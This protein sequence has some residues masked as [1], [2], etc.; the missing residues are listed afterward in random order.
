MSGHPTAASNCDNTSC[1]D[2]REVTVTRSRL[3]RR[4]EISVSFIIQPLSREGARLSLSSHVELSMNTKDSDEEFIVT[5][6]LIV[7]DFDRSVSF[8]RDIL[9]ATVLRKGE[10]TLVRL[11]NIGSPSTSA[12]DQLMISR[13]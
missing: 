2:L 1:K 13:R 4:V 6:I 12:A 8:Y 11:A 7:A 9:G 10:P 3:I 5:V